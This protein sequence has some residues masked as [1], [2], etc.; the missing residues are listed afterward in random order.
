MSCPL[1][2]NRLIVLMPSVMEM[3]P[4]RRGPDAGPS[5]FEQELQRIHLESQHG[6]QI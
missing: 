5:T 2:I 4:K 3:P 1:L 6:I